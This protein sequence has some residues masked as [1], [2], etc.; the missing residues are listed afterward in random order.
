M[1]EDLK[2][3][4]YA[5][6]FLTPLNVQKPA[7]ET[8]PEVANVPAMPAPDPTGVVPG[9]NSASKGRADTGSILPGGGRKRR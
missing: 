1:P 5:P 7:G 9:A 6:E 8:G 2:S 4:A 3:K